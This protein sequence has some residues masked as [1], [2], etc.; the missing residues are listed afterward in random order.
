MDLTDGLIIYCTEHLSRALVSQLGIHSSL[1]G[2]LPWP[3]FSGF[4]TIFGAL[5]SKIN[6]YTLS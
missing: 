4:P 2:L 3:K 5:N 6:G 1:A